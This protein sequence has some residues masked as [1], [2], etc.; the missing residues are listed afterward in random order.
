MLNGARA[1][2]RRPFQ[3]ERLG[4]I[5]DDLAAVVVYGGLYN[6]YATD[7]HSFLR[8]EYRMI[9]LALNAGLP[10]LGI[11]QGAQMIAHHLG[12]WVGT[13]AHGQHEFGYYT[14]T[15]TEAGRSLLP[16]PLDMCR[17]HCHTYDLPDGA[18]HLARSEM[19]EQQAFSYGP[20][21]YGFQSHPENTL[22]GFRRWQRHVTLKDRPGAQSWQEQ[23]ARMLAA[24]RAQADWFYGFLNDFLK[25][26]KRE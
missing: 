14:V 23:E 21:C 20:V 4:E 12:A 11:C 15:P 18:V 5:T 8:E 7:E 13:P 9:D 1:D 19:F 26:A 25:G 6:A 24:D 22:E 17:A 10:L 2:I 3:A 16:D